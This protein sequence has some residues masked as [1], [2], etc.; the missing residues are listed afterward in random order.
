MAGNQGSSFRPSNSG[1]AGHMGTVEIC[2]HLL[3]EDKFTEVA[4][5]VHPIHYAWEQIYEI[6]VICFQLVRT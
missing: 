6:V 2:P 3:L 4:D 5:Y 1:L